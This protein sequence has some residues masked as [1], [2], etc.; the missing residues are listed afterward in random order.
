MNEGVEEILA[1][2]IP[3][4]EKLATKLDNTASQTVKLDVDDLT[5]S[6]K[7][8]LKILFDYM[9]SEFKT[10]LEAIVSINETLKKNKLGGDSSESGKPLAEDGARRVGGR[11]INVKIEDIN[12]RVVKLIRDEILEA[13][14]VTKEKE[15]QEKTKPSYLLGLLALIAGVIIGI[16]SY[17]ND[18][19]K[20]I[21]AFF[22]RLKIFDFIGDLLRAFKNKVFKFF[23]GVYR[24]I[25]ESKLAQRIRGFFSGVWQRIANSRLGIFVT[26]TFA[27]IK[28]AITESKLFKSLSSLF[29]DESFLGKTLKRISDFFKGEGAAGRAIQRVGKLF[30]FVKNTISGFLGLIGKIVNAGKVAIKTAFN[31]LKSSPLFTVGKVIGRLLGPILLIFELITNT[32]DSIKEQGLSFK[33]VMDGLLGGIVSF[34]TLGILN[35]RNIKN[36]SDKI[37]QAFKEGNIVEGVMR[38]ILAIPDLIFQGIGKITSFIV[39]F[40]G[41]PELKATVENFFKGGLTD[42]IIGLSRQIISAITSPIVKLLSVIKR[43]FNIDVMAWVNSMID[44]VPGA[45]T[46]FNFA[47]GQTPKE[48]EEIVKQPTLTNLKEQEKKPGVFDDLF[49]DNEAPRIEAALDSKEGDYDDNN[50]MQQPSD[51]EEMTDIAEE[52]NIDIKQLATL[53]KEQTEILKQTRDALASMRPNTNI[54]SINS[55]TVIQNHD[56]GIN[57]WRQSVHSS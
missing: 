46:L 10:Y 26:E 12:P 6:K 51:F 19:W 27:R 7:A 2:L 11:I 25:A 45:R 53:M 22:G 18:W 4:I 39:G 17:I 52:T 41:G 3:A 15:K 23:S 14:S 54:S 49:K 28:K 55:N 8:K 30:G 33:S 29:S 21:R 38:I 47:K 13:L 5:K 1:A 24:A 20:K 44:K 50:I 9:K 48:R 32:I 40:F 36:I 35:F 16:L 42:K 34:L 31:I 37:T 56:N 43:V 57:A